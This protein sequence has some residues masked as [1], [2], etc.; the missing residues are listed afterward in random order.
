M[1]RIEACTA[2]LT[3]ILLFISS[4]GFSQNSPVLKQQ[5]NF[6]LGIDDVVADY[7]FGTYL[8]KTADSYT[9]VD[10]ATKIQLGTVQFEADVW[11]APGVGKMAVW[12]DGKFLVSTGFVLMLLDPIEQ[13]VDT[14]FNKIEFPEIIE[15]FIPM[16]GNDGQ[17]LIA[18][19]IYELKKDK[20]ISYKDE[21]GNHEGSK[22]CR[23]I[24]YDA[25]TNTIVKAVNTQHY[26]TVFNSSHTTAGKI[27]AGT[28]EGD[29]LE[30]DGN[31]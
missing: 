22:N 9:L 5:V 23:L 17:V 27:L 19:K 24:L 13:T 14:F 21:N 20:S 3:A 16:P 28:F 15:N 1:K 8:V 12:K 6:E 11:G 2:V 30:I 26:I 10:Q 18:T 4:V 31:L 25:K 7:T 29:I